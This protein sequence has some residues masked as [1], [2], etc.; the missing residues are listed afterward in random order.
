[1]IPHNIPDNRVVHAKVPMNQ[2]ITHAGH[3]APIDARMVPSKLFG[4]VLGSLTNDLDASD[5]CAL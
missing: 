5:E 4:H 3:A 1:M 2:T